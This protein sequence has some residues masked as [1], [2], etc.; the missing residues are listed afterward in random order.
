M[1]RQIVQQP[2]IIRALAETAKVIDRADNSLAKMPLPE[3]IDHHAG[4]QRMVWLR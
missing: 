1:H 2:L 3:A 4:G